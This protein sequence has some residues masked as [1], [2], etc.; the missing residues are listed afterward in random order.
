MREKKLTRV[1]SSLPGRNE[2]D[3]DDVCPY[4]FPSF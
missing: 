1:D 4:A 2:Q 3:S